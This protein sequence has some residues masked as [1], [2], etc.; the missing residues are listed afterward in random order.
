[1]NKNSLSSPSVCGPRAS[2][3]PNLTLIEIN[4][5]R[6]KYPRG[7]HNK[8]TT[9]DYVIDSCDNFS[10]ANLRLGRIPEIRIELRRQPSLHKL[11]IQ[12]TSDVESL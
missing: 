2:H 12:N 3:F 5:L 10:N 11:M 9:R 8:G 6:S 4:Y 1:M 7:F